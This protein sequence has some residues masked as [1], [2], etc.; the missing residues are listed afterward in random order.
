M[1]PESVFNVEESIVRVAGSIIDDGG[2]VEVRRGSLYVA[3]EIT[4]DAEDRYDARL[5]IGPN[6]HVSVPHLTSHKGGTIDVRGG[7]LAV[8]IHLAFTPNPPG[9]LPYGDLNIFD[10][11]RIDVARNA[12]LPIQM[13][14]EIG[15]PGVSPLQPA[16]FVDGYVDFKGESASNRARLNVQFDPAFSPKAGDLFNLFDF[17]DVNGAFERIQLPTLPSHLYWNTSMLLV[18]GTL[19]IGT[20]GQGDFNLDGIVDAADYVVWRNGLGT[21]YSQADYDLWRSNFGRTIGGGAEAPPASAAVPESST[22]CLLLIA[23]VG[24]CFWRS[25]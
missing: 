19:S 21:A 8:E 18:N 12:T 23:T 22:T 6:G 1:T 10:G 13:N 9:E 25:H 20:G 14:I 16:I 7:S 24:L 5:D 4:L 3:A 11:G 2:R 17:G 15:E